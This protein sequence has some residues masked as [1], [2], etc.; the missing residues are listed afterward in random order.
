MDLFEIGFWFLFLYRAHLV[1]FGYPG[2]VA[3]SRKARNTPSLYTRRLLC[4]ALN[5]FV[6]LIIILFT[7]GT[8]EF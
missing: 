4:R 6:S 8:N 1:A 3:E 7:P 2:G 5:T